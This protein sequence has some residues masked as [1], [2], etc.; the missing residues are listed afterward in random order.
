M[1]HFALFQTGNAGSGVCQIPLRGKQQQKITTI[2]VAL[3][4][5]ERSLTSWNLIAAVAVDDDDATE[6]MSDEIVNQSREQIEPDARL[7]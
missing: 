2:T 7:G 1:S 5:L 3:S 6:A 4:D